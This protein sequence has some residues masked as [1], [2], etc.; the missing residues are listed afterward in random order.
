MLVLESKLRGTDEQYQIIDEMI[1]TAQFI[2]NS[3]IR[4][5]MD[6]RGV[7]QYDLSKLCAVLAKEYKWAGSLNSMARQASAERAWAAIK[8]F[9]VNCRAEK[10][11]KKGFPRFKKRSHSVK[12]KTSGW[13][14]SQDRLQLTFIDGFKAGTFQLIGTRDLKFYHLQQIKRVRVVR[15]ADGYYAQ[16]C[17]DVERKEEHEWSGRVVGIDVGLEY[18]YTDSDGN[19]VENPRFLRKS[20]LALK[21]VQRRVSSRKKGSKNRNKAINRMARKHLKVSRQRRDFAVKAALS[22]VRSSDL[23]VYE[24]L[25]VRNMV[26]NHHLAKSISD[27]SWSLFLEWVEYF[28]KIHGIVVVVVPQGGSAGEASPADTPPQ[29]TS[30]DCSGCG[31]RQKKT[32]STRTHQCVKCGLKLHRDTPVRST[33]GTPARDWLH[34]SAIEIKKKGLKILGENTAGLAGIHACGQNAL[35]LDEE[36]LSDKVAGRSRKSIEQSMESPTIITSAKRE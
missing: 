26:R 35:C 13:K 22:L 11:G 27:V 31:H 1:R 30:Q 18:F 15:R 19:T 12:Y 16:F 33:G 3:C 20:E 32:L 8:R 21:R 5:W 28:G 25:Q 9:Y 2:R 17:V 10:P 4:Y 29:Y 34:N 24:N 36:T 7:G 6:N 23:I 14:L